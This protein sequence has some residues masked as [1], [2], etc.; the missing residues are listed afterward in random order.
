M[1]IHGLYKLTLL[2]F[3]E[4][5]ACT[6]FTGGCNF[7][8]PFCHNASLV[9][10]LNNSTSISEEEIFSFLQS[11][12][13][14]LD[15]ICISGG[16]PTLQPDLYNFI[17]KVKNLGFKVKL[18]TNGSNP[19]ILSKLLE[20]Q[21]LDYVAMDIKNSMSKYAGTIDLPNYDLTRI[22]SSIDLLSNSAI[23]FEFRTTVVKEL[24]TLEDFLEIAEW[25]PSNSHYYLQSFVDSKDLIKDGFTG[26][27]KE[28]MYSFVNILRPLLPNVAV[29][30]IE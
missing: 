2:D 22:K 16:E 17:Q 26:Y 27:S 6:I 12:I 18:D 7:L 20:T 10:H 19:D 5:I 4:H 25:I 14:I 29:R 30:G 11:R 1:N 13:N 24:H 21:L 3:P 15:G 23:N 9:T 8:C 28:E